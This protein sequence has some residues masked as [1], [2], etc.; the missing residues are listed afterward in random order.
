MKML[1]AT[2]VGVKAL[3]QHNERLANPLDP[4]AKD[5]ARLTSKRKKTESDFLAISEVEFVGGL[6]HDADAGPYIPDKV[7]RSMMIGAARKMKLG[8]QV[9]ENI[10]LLSPMF[11]LRYKGPRDVAGLWKAGFYDRR[12]VG[13]QSRRILR[14]RP[15]FADWSLPVSIAFDEIGIDDRQMIDIINRAG[16][17]GIGD[18][19][20][21]FGTFKV[22]DVK[23][24]DMA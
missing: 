22:K 17:L 13:N 21:V 4:A 10:F 11:P 23:V 5:L 1:T 6:Y 7:I 16:T 3:L 8:K 19:R 2:L 20:P 12:M 14:T 24:G 9:E 18:Y 15:M